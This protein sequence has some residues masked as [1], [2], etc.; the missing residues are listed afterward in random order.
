MLNFWI[1]FLK[2]KSFT[3]MAMVALTVV[4]LYTV[5]VIPKESAPE[6]II[7][8]GVVSTVLRGGSSEDV[9]KLVTNKLEQEIINVENIDKVT[10]SS[11]EGVSVIT[12]Q[13]I[14]SA[15][16]EK[17]IQNLKDA[18]DK[19]KVGLPADV[20]DPQVLKINFA[21]Q[22]VLIFSVSSD[23]P[24]KEI[25]RMSEDLEREIKKVKGVSEVDL[26]GVRDR[27]VQVVISKEKLV[28]YG[29][30]IN[31]VIGAIQNS[32]ASAPIGRITISDVDYPIQFSGSIEETSEIPDII[33]SNS[34][35]VPVYL[36]DIAYISDGLE[37]PKTFSRISVG[38]S[39]SEN[40]ITVAVRKKSGGDVTEITK[41]VL[42]K[43]EE[44]K[45]PGQLLSGASVVVTIDAGREVKK[46][47]V[48]LS[49][50]GLETVIL[51]MLIL[52]LAIGWRESLV[53]GLSIPL[54]F[55]I[56]FIGLYVSGNTINFLSLFSLILAIGILVDSG[57]VVAEAIHT[58]LKNYK[59]LD[60]KIAIEK[61]A[62]ESI[63]E[64]SR[65]LIAGTLTT[66]AAFVPLFFLTG[67]V[68]QFVKSIPFTIVFVLIASIFVAL[69]MVPILAVFFA[70]KKVVHEVK[71]SEDEANYSKKIE[72][73]QEKYFHIAQDW[74]KKFLGNILLNR[75]IQNQF[76]IWITILFFASFLIP[77]FGIVKAELFPQEDQPF[78]IV[79][80]EKKE[81]STLTSTDLA[82]RQVEEILYG[83]SFVESFVTT[84]GAG[85]ALSER[86]GGVN[87]KLANITVMLK[88]KKD[89]SENSTEITNT[90]RNEFSEITDGKVTIAQLNN[91]PQSG[92]PIVVKLT[93]EN[94]DRLTEATEKVELLLKSIPGSR[95]VA[96]SVKDDGTE[97]EISVDR[98]KASEYGLT[99]SA[100]AQILRASV[101]GVTA[102]TIK[103]QESDI[104][105][106]V[107]VALN[108]DFV[109]VEDTTKTTLDSIKN[110][111]I[112][113]PTG[114]TVLLGSILK[115]NVSPSRVSIS[116][117][118]Q[119]RIST[120]NAD[121]KTGFNAL[122]V[123]TEL[124][125][126][127]KEKYGE[128]LGEGVTV[129]YGGDNEDIQNT[130]RDMIL[131][132]VALLFLMLVILVL[133][134]GSF[135]YSLYLLLAIPLSLIGVFAGLA[136][137]GQSLSFSAMLGIIALAGVIINHAII[138][139][140][141]ILRKL[142]EEKI[143]EGDTSFH[144]KDLEDEKEN[145]L[146]DAIVESS[147]V[148]L[149]PIFLTTATTVVGMIP[150]AGVSALWGPLAFTIMFGLAFSMVLTLVLIPLLFYRFPGKK[151]SHLK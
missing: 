49:R 40:A 108:D 142:E 112:P 22:P 66:V 51:V 42:A 39:P 104:D 120:V 96:T 19:A 75:K 117:E 121:V 139:L 2:N 1:F 141:S 95:D 140:D 132:L 46:D 103:R 78:I 137:T 76:F 64:Y 29:V 134:F 92:K 71:L 124:Q 18:V 8:I 135:R 129:V 26:S 43:I 30:S 41:N 7:P 81:G 62:I 138:L 88:D 11:N 16:V 102:T 114:G 24:Q 70:K 149:R 68:G 119:K 58:R 37:S 47:L 82:V 136:I 35:N 144:L 106:L 84:V 93:G 130:F 97:L 147:A 100:V 9:E 67:I 27:Q 31:Q 38:G 91:G 45:A 12:A 13:F 50:T 85:S 128:N 107:K 90:L 133:E 4:G 131:A 98:V 36:K 65:P 105:V 116:H 14:A 146:F 87:S 109:N 6:V 94:L 118:N 73:F 74:Y 63:Q 69:G 32:N 21:D 86:G 28:Q 34:L 44:L 33:V 145:R 55:V 52:F 3:W 56:A 5:L 25:T 60:P 48:D 17:S 57:I 113:T 54:S 110:L 115:T 77:G 150:L 15:D 122:E 61:A 20:D 79:N 99:S 53:A 101:S 72:I 126:M 148:R 125:K 10:S 80:I 111:T 83:K 143:R 23:L 123:T 89:R 127:I 151:Y 59:G